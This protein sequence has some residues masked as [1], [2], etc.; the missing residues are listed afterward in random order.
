MLVHCDLV[1]SCG[2][3]CCCVNLYNMVTLYS[4]ISAVSCQPG[5][6]GA[7]VVTFYAQQVREI[8]LVA[9]FLVIL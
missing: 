9:R 7:G 4:V 5:K 6:A 3:L 1:A 8:A 2:V